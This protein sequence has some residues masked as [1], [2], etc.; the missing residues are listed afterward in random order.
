MLTIDRHEIWM[1][2]FAL[3]LTAAL[4][5]STAKAQEATQEAS[6]A[7]VTEARGAP[8]GET[9]SIASNASGTVATAEPLKEVEVKPAAK[10]EATHPAGKPYFIE[11]RARSAYSYG[12]TFLVH[13]RVGQKITRRDV[14]GLHPA[15]ESPTPWMIG[16][17]I[18]VVSET[19]ASDG[20]YEEPYVIARYR[21]LLSEPEYKRILAH[22]RYKQAHSPLWHA[23]LYNCNRFVGEIAEYMGLRA[24]FNALQMPKEYINELKAMN[25]G[26]N[27]LSGPVQE[28]SSTRSNDS[29]ASSP[30]KPRQQTAGTRARHAAVPVRPQPPAQSA[31]SYAG[32]Q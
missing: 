21:I 6:A 11:F 26:R 4:S 2:L 31:G 13:G 1:G 10:P 29:V 12:H 25:G 5:H 15:T 18:P 17:L 14:V 27:Q 32:V 22:M 3:A 30:P 8:T 16:H 23:V 28:A 24:P 20:D 19:G 9:G 7:P